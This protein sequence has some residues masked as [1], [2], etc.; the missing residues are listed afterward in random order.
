[1]FKNGLY[2]LLLFVILLSCSDKVTKYNGFIQSELE[3]LLA[4]NVGK[5]W[6]RV[7]VEENGLVIAPEDCG[8]DN[9]LIFWQGSVGLEKPLLYAYNPTTCDS[10][11]FCNLRPE[12]CKADTML[13]NADPEFCE[14]FGDEV[15]YIGSWYAKAP[16]IQNSRSDTLIFNINNKTES[17]FVTSISSQNASFQYKSRTGSEGGLI[18]EYYKFTAQ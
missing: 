8:M 7:S 18:T 15:L 4:S 14:L 1:M 13:C 6:E 9:F 5:V 11:E 17:V 3:Y 10:L 12:F 16:F 2:Y